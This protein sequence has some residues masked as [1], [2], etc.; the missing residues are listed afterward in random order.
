MQ[1]ELRDYADF[2]DFQPEYFLTF[3][4]PRKL[5]RHLKCE[6]NLVVAKTSPGIYHISKEIFNTQIIV[7]RE[8]SSEENL[9]LRCL[10]NN[11]KDSALI[12]R[13][14]DDYYLPQIDYL[15]NLLTQNNISFDL[16][17]TPKGTNMPNQ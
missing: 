11:L 4:Y 3:H 9:Y 6:R 15:K 7:T 1:I 14:A 13:L 16:N 17:N 8:L 12:N 5:I 2:L 10:N